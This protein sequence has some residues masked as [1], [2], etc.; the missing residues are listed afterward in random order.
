MNKCLKILIVVVIIGLIFTIIDQIKADELVDNLASSAPKAENMI[1]ETDCYRA[2]KTAVQYWQSK[3]VQT[4]A[5]IV[6]I[7]D[8]GGELKFTQPSTGQV[9]IFNCSPSVGI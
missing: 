5:A 8:K 1:S 9:K 2:A 7:C 3:L 6:A 4:N